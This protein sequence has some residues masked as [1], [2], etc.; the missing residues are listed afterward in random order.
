M[1]ERYLGLT[2]EQLAWTLVGPTI[3][4]VLVFFQTAG[5]LALRAGTAAAIVALGVVVTFLAIRLRNRLGG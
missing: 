1:D 4:G 5:T 3:V 2:G